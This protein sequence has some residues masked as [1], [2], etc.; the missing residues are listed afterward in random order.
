MSYRETG[1]GGNQQ[2][3]LVVPS[4]LIF[5]ESHRPFSPSVV[6]H[7][8]VVIL[9][10][11]GSYMRNPVTVAN[12]P[13]DCSVDSSDKIAPGIPAYFSSNLRAIN[14]ITSVMAGPIRNGANAL[15]KLLQVCAAEL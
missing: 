7:R 15:A 8:F 5:P 2:P 1:S 9:V 14:G 4:P 10:P 13:L 11:T 6:V 3:F 12:I